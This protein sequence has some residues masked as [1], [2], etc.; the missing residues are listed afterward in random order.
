MYKNRLRSFLTKF[1]LISTS[2]YGFLRG[3]STADAMIN[4]TEQLFNDFH[5][6]N[7][8]FSVYVDLRKA[9][10]TINHLILLREFEEIGIRGVSLEFFWKD[11]ANRQQFVRLKSTNSSLK[12]ICIGVLQVRILSRFCS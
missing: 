8:I 10:D 4:L 9:F 1:L 7:H 2:Q 5:G 11:L 3:V 6:K 12:Q